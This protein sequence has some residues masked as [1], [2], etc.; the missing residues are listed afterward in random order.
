MTFLPGEKRK[1]KFAAAVS[2]R[3]DIFLYFDT[4]PQREWPYFKI[5]NENQWKTYVFF[6]E[7]QILNKNDKKYNAK[8]K[9]HVFD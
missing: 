4:G 2:T 9:K 3:R 1:L 5:Y 6:L 8:P 7:I